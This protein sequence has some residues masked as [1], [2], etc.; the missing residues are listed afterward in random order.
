VLA[1]KPG[2]CD[3]SI[4][5]RPFMIIPLIAS[6]GNSEEIKLLLRTRSFW[7]CV[8]ALSQTIRLFALVVKHEHGSLRLP[9]HLAQNSPLVLSK[10]VSQV[11]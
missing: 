8:L 5:L 3:K 4:S 10:K 11:P 2:F 7:I 6:T 9:L 1:I